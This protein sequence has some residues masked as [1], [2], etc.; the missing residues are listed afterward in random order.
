MRQGTRAGVC[1]P[2]PRPFEEKHDT[3]RA[4]RIRRIGPTGD[5]HPESGQGTRH[6]AIPSIS[7]P[8]TPDTRPR[9]VY[10]SSSREGEGEKG[11]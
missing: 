10:V 3:R 11:V 8:A 2:L 4:A 1:F 9:L 7:H 6:T 5:H